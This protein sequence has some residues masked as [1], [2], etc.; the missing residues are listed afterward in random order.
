MNEFTHSRFF[1][2]PPVC[3]TVN[4]VDVL[5]LGVEEG[6]T[7]L[8]GTDSQGLTLGVTGSISYHRGTVFL[9]CPPQG[10]LCGRVGEPTGAGSRARAPPTTQ[11]PFAASSSPLSRGCPRDQKVTSSP[12]PPRP[13]PLFFLTGYKIYLV[14]LADSLSRCPAWLVVRGFFAFLWGSNPLNQYLFPPPLLTDRDC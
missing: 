3:L 5:P 9:L 1:S 10:A 12:A 13:K 14:L 8:M 7:V 2:L 6:A 11:Q 4:R